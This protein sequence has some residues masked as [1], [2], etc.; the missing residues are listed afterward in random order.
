MTRHFTFH[1]FLHAGRPML[2]LCL[3]FL[4]F[5]VLSGLMA[6]IDAAAL[7][8]TRPEVDEM[9]VA[10]RWGAKELRTVKQELTR[11]VVVIVILTNTVNILGP[12]IVSQQ[13][14]T[15]F[16]MQGLSVVT[17]LLALGTMVF[18]EIIPKAIGTHYAPIISRLSA[19]VICGLQIVLLPLVVSLECIS[20]LFTTGT[21]YI[22]TEEQIRSL[23]KIGRQAGYIEHDEG[24]MIHRAFTL[25][26]RTASEIMTPLRNVVSVDHTATLG[27][28]VKLVRGTNYSR[29]PVFGENAN[30]IQGMILR[31]E[32][33]EAVID[34]HVD[35]I[36]QT[37]SRE[38][39][40]VDVSIPSDRLL[41]LFRERQSHFAIVREKNTTV[42]V[43]TLKDV[44][45]ELVG[46]IKDEKD[47]G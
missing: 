28:A 32:L 43:V 31:S 33:L 44:L 10:G 46:E 42:G 2:V 41:I 3:T 30:D 13:A 20:G 38:V 35:H 39:L 34:Q 19:P 23:T 37:V 26:D 1:Q 22:G 11:A 4:S 36:V 9:I 15:Q 29:F 17:I 12:I 14:F 24:Q 8:V 25:N 40:M 16:G 18:S 21:R 5:L 7:S 27:E 47:A 6:A 45:E